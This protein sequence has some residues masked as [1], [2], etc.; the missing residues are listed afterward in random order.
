[1]KYAGMNKNDFS[2]GPG[3]CV[4]FFTQGCPHHCYKCQNPET[5]DFGG[6]KEF[7]NDT[8]NEILIALTANGIKRN[9]AIM[10]GEPMCQE[11]QFLT[12]IVVSTVKEKLPDTK[13]Y[14][15]TGYNLEDL[16]RVGL[17]NR[18]SS[19]LSLCDIVVDGPYIE[20]ERDTT[21]P[22]RGSRNQRIINK[23]EILDFIGKL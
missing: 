9:L 14:L 19:I 3:T 22:M 5:W 17:P 12:Q 1:M 20:A 23:E 6:G 21:L 16:K 7:T 10:G 4:T 13:I 11:N 18:V 2:A 15:W 8:L